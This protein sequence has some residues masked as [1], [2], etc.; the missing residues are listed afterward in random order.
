MF[1]KKKH[2]GC[3]RACAPVEDKTPEAL[4]KQRTIATLGKH[5]VVLGAD[6]AERTGLFAGAAVKIFGENFDVIAVLPRTG[7]VDDDRVF[8]HLHTIQ[9]LTGAGPNVSAIEVMAC[10]EDAAGDLVAE[11]EALLPD[12]KVVTI[13]HVVETQV[14]VNRL[15]G[16]VSLFVLVV[17]VVVGGLS[18]AGAIASN[19]RE[20][21]REI[22][23]LMALGAS[24][25]FIARLFVLKGLAVG[26]VGGALGTAIGVAVA[27]LCGPQLAGVS[28]APLP[29]LIALALAMSVVVSFV[30]AWWP[31]RGASQLDPC[32]CFQEV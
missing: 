6:A 21:R 9:D 12:S 29:T 17:L 27:V 4:A 1:T 28:V 24:P 11:L 20:R 18:V 26:I 16:N 13:N 23:T 22:G 30:A 14:G 3:K 8:A 5:E 19:V 15:L 2:V 31:A 25:G 7:T 32:C 10:C